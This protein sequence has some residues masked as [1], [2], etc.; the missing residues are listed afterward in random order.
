MPDWPYLSLA[1]GPGEVTNRTLRDH[2]RPI[3]NHYAP[4]FIDLFGRTTDLLKSVF[5]TQHDAVIMQGETVLG[6][7]AVAAS[8]IAPGDKVLNLVSGAFG[9]W[10]QTFIDRYGGETIELAVPYNEAIDPEEVRNALRRHRGV[11]F[12][13]VI[14]AETPSGTVN[15]I[16][17]I[18]PIA[19]E[20]GVLTIVDTALGLGG[21][22]VRTDAWGIDV[23]V[24]GPQKCLAG[25]PGLALLAVSPAAWEIMERRNAPLRE[26]YLSLLDWR[27][28]WLRTRSFPYTV[29]VSLVYALESVLAQ[30][31]E[32]GLDRHVASHARIGRA[33]RAGVQALGLTC[34]PARDEIASSAVTVV[35]TPEGIQAADLVAWMR[36]RYG[37]KISGGYKELAGKTFRLGHMGVSAHPTHLAALLA[38]LARGLADLEMKTDLGAGVGA[39]MTLLGDW[40]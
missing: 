29:S 30:V 4:A 34:W 26:S 10:F 8:L 23:A 20:F 40:E 39:A 2:I 22:R 18:C 31:L 12:L 17:I 27:D 14:H 32:V 21:E 35:R 16:E 25:V 5:Q 38:I 6:M 15:P 19:K 33:C 3:V 7:E 36:E 9:K 1:S 11:K 37:V 24:S 28:S 13:S